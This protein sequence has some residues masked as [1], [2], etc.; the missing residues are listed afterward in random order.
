MFAVCM[1][2][3]AGLA[4]T[5]PRDASQKTKAQPVSGL[6]KPMLTVDDRSS[7]LKRITQSW[8]TDWNRHT[9][10]YDEI[11]S[12][13]PPRDGIR[14]IDKPK[15]ISIDMAAQFFDA[16]EPVVVLDIDGDAR[17]YPLQILTWHEIVND[18]VGSVPV[19][20]TFCPLCNSAIAFDRRFDGKTHEFG[21]SGLLRYSDL[22]MYDRTTESLWQQFTGEGVVGEKAGA[23][24][25]FLPASLISFAE[26]RAA[27]P[28]GVVLSRDTGSVRSYGNNPYKGYDTIGN[29]P[30]MFRGPTDDRL[31]AMARVVSVS[32]ETVDIAYPLSVVAEQGIIHDIQ[33]GRSLVVFHTTGT[34]SALGSARIAEGADVGATGVFD[35]TVDGQTLTF[36]R[37]GNDI[38]DRETQSTWNILGHAVK[39]PLKG[40]RLTPII[41][42]DHFWFS[43]AAF[44][45]NTILYWVD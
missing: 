26:F 2:V 17:A 33:A 30:F 41:H 23:Y 1:D 29:T 7:R 40:Q 22:I 31:P 21:T 18:T 43:W 6:V 24:L 15:F 9:I 14:S 39:G 42:G 25:R 13:G 28:Q 44:K 8:N 27:Y 32:L 37:T 36:H 5:Q 4:Q 16:T 11:L 45:P 12:G 3:M 20:I 38:V 34:N 10:R 35:P 19:V